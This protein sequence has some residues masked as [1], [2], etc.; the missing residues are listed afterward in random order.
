MWSQYPT[1][2]VSDSWVPA[3]CLLQ[4]QS[5]LFSY[6]ADLLPSF[7][8]QLLLA[9]AGAR[10]GICLFASVT[11]WTFPFP[12]TPVTQGKKKDPIDQHPSPSKGG[13]ELAWVLIFFLVSFPRPCQIT[14]TLTDPRAITW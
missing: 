3:I 4:N 2:R 5:R 6:K 9:E 8:I 7:S 12:S 11:S 10:E 1:A 13:S 14:W